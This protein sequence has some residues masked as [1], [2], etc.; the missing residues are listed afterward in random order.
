MFRN[1]K[2]LTLGVFA[3]LFLSVVV[4]AATVDK[5]SGVYGI[6]ANGLNRVFVLKNTVDISEAANGDVYQV[7]KVGTGTV[8]MNVFT[9][10]VEANDAATSSAAD[11]GDGSD[12]NGYDNAIDM[13]AVAGTFT[14]GTSTDA[15]VTGHGKLYTGADTIDLTFAVT[16]TNSTGI[17]KVKA[18][19]LDLN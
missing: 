17:V 19:C 18:L 1:L 13:K 12:P 14:K 5:T 10:I 7:L 3:S 15:Y 16:G 9:E 11:V 4:N 8:V 2:L 6:P